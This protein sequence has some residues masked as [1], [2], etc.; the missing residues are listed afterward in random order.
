MMNE[1]RT[2]LNKNNLW[3]FV[4]VLLL[5]PVNLSLEALKWKSLVKPLSP[6]DFRTSLT[7]IFNGIALSILTP[8]RVGEYGGRAV[9]LKDNKMS[10]LVSTF[11]GNIGQGIIN[12]LIGL[13]AFY[14]FIKKFELEGQNAKVLVPV[15][16]VISLL[17]ILCYFNLEW[18]FRRLN[19]MRFIRKYSNYFDVLKVYDN[20][21]LF[22]VLSLSVLKYL[23][24]VGQFVLLIMLFGIDVP[25]FWAVVCVSCIFFVK[26][27][28]P[29][30]A[31]VELA[32][33]GLIAITFFGAITQNE[34]GILVASYLLWIIN[35]A[36]PA[37]IGSYL[38]TKTKI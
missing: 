35:L 29:L 1:F 30:P 27:A 11:V 2:N 17:M 13:G 5:M 26:S 3:L 21:T 6:I 36:I 7:A 10:A 4:A 15:A 19:N 33:R 8:K 37:L 16:I 9:T 32:T 20:E 28:L 24:F 22:G 14:L 38:L 12:L 31:T 18:V 23:V 25:F 34:I